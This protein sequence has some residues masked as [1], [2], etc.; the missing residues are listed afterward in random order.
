MQHGRPPQLELTTLS[1][2]LCSA[3]FG[4]VAAIVQQM[5]VQVDVHRAN[6]GARAAK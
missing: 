1:G 6:A 4:E 2:C 5:M 3:G